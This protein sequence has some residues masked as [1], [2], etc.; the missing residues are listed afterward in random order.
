MKNKHF[1]FILFY[2]HVHFERTI[3]Q[4]IVVNNS[5]L[6]NYNLNNSTCNILTSQNVSAQIRCLILCQSVECKNVEYDQNSYNCTIY[7]AQPQL[8]KFDSLPDMNLTYSLTSYINYG[9][10]CLFNFTCYAQSCFNGI[11][12]SFDQQK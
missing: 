5:T 7:D 4:T 10:S 8:I 3:Q 9:E 11:C 1:T 12:C 2:I 6:L